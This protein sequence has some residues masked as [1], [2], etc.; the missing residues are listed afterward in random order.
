MG[1]FDVFGLSVILAEDFSKAGED[2]ILGGITTDFVYESLGIESES[3]RTWEVFDS[4][5]GD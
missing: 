3:K 5:G 1:I 2:N 4:M